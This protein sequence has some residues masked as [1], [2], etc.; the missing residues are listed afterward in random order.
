LVDDDTYDAL[1]RFNWRVLI[2]ANGSVYAVTRARNP[3]GKCFK[4]QMAYL[5]LGIWPQKGYE[6]DHI[7]RN[8]LNNQRSN[9]RL[10]E[11]WQNA[12]NRRTRHGSSKFRGVYHEPDTDRWTAKITARRRR[13]CLG[14]FKT[15]VEAARAYNQAALTHHGEFAQLNVLPDTD[16]DQVIGKLEPAARD[17]E[18]LRD[19]LHG[20]RKELTETM[21]MFRA[22]LK[23]KIG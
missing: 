5:I 15:E 22:Y 21:A 1:L 3:T 17:L 4:V 20:F 14:T 12:V 9:L 18:D 16:D 7:D 19:E 13:S 8:S 23:R 11:C 6:I 10:C 2:T